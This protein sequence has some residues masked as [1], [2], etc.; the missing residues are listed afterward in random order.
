MCLGPAG[1]PM[2]S[3]HKPRRCPNWGG[4]LWVPMA[5]LCAASFFL[6]AVLLASSQVSKHGPFALL[7]PEVLFVSIL[8]LALMGL[9]IQTVT[10][11]NL[12][13]DFDQD[14]FEIRTLLGRTVVEHSRIRAYRITKKQIGRIADILVFE[15]DDASE[16]HVY[17]APDFGSRLYWRIREVRDELGLD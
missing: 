8:G 11:M 16:A 13:I 5:G 15:L 12:W 1:T 3:R 17:P 4:L 14:R 10:C 6:L 7:R 2:N 9:S